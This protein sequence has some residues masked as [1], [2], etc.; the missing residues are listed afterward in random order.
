MVLSNLKIVKQIPRDK[1]LI[2][3]DGPYSRVN[4]KKYKPELLRK[5]YEIISNKL[6]EPELTTIVF[7]NFKRL[8]MTK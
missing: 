7:Q 6:N 1:I 2:E 5:E 4:G 3:S 8:L